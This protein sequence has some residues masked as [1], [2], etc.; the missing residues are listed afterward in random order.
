M[1]VV[2]VAVASC[3]FI[4]S[5]AL[6]YFAGLSADET[7]FGAHQ[8]HYLA[9]IMPALFL[10]SLVWVWRERTKKPPLQDSNLR[11]YG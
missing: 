6:G 5:L 10:V 7:H 1:K 2:S 3:L 4:V 8:W 11:P 9:W